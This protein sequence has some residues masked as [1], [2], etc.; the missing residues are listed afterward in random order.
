MNQ[1]MVRFSDP[2]ARIP[3]P[4]GPMPPIHILTVQGHPEFTGSIVKKIIKAR[5][6]KG[7]MDKD[8][9]EDGSKRADDRNDGDDIARA[10]WEILVQ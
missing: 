9:A 7:V 1:G 2:H 4:D 10:I 6:E 5:S 8:T 3:G